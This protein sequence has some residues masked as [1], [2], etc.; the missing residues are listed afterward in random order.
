VS[1]RGLNE[2]TRQDRKRAKRAARRAEHRDK[3]EGR[4]TDPADREMQERLVALAAMYSKE[5]DRG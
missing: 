3:Y 4:K 5:A 2:S 1:R